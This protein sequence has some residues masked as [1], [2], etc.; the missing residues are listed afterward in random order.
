MVY[1]ILVF[2]G[3]CFGS[4]SEA[5]TWRL[6]QQSLPKKKRAASDRELSMLHGR[7]MCPNCKHTLGFFDLVPLFSWLALK[8]RCRYCGQNIGW[9]SPVLELG[10]ASLFVA[11]Y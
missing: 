2:L 10:M 4:F 1:V 7:S 9:H 5:L 6:H 11:S 3:L 8:G